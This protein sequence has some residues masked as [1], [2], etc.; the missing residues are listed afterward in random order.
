MLFIVIHQVYELWFK[1]ILH[2]L[3]YLQRAARAG[4]QRPRARDAEARPHDPQDRRRADRRARDDDA[5]AS[6]RPSAAGSTPRA[7]SSRRSS[8]SSRSMLGR[9]DERMLDPYAP[10][11]PARQRIARGDGAPVALRLVP[12]LPRRRRASRVPGDAPRA[13]DGHRAQPSPAVQQRAPR[14]RT[15]TTREAAQVCERFVDLDEG[16]QE[17]RYRHVKMVERTIGEKS[18]DRRLARARATCAPRSS[19]PP[20]R[21]SGRSASEL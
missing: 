21:T 10:E 1:Q 19:P 11:S 18:R 16:F 7:A 9:R 5:R 17:W 4:R 8:A 14:G 15:A 13:V 2:E 6:S 3:A 20:S 12:A